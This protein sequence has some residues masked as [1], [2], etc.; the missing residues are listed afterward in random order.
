MDFVIQDVK[1]KATTYKGSEIK[2]FLFL[3]IRLIDDFTKKEPIGYVKVIIKEGNI[4]AVKNLSGC[5]TFTNLAVDNYT[6]EINSDLYF[7]EELIDIPEI[8]NSKN[9]MLK[10]CTKGPAF[11]ATCTKLKDVSRLHRGEIIEFRNLDGDVEKRNITIVDATTDEISW[12]RELEYNF[13]DEGC[14]VLVH[15]HPVVSVVLK[16]LRFYPFPNNATLIRGL[17]IDSSKN[18]MVDKRVKVASYEIETKSDKSGEFVLYFNNIKDKKI[19]VEIT[20]N[21]NTKFINTELEE[22]MTQSLGKI[23]CS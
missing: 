19:S 2:T 4:R 1:D 13:T 3:A 8:I 5:Y 16:P 18:P 7:P 15:K 22:G 10:F 21:G 17:L 12:A 14:A 23:V 20:T 9:V 11:G 6:I